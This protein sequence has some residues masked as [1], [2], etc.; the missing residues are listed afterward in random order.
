MNADGVRYRSGQG[1]GVVLAAVLGSGMAM[2]DGTV[3]NVALRS[4]GEDLHASLAQLQWI[5]NGY[6]LSLASLI[7]IGGSLGDRYGRRKIFLI[8]VVAFAVAS[9]ACGLAQGPT[10][11]ITARIIQGVGAALLTPGSLSMIQS[12]F[13][14][15]DRGPAIGAW[16]G[17][18][19]IA[20]AIGPFIGGGLLAVADW[21][22]LFWLNLPIA[23][24]TVLCTLRFVPESRSTRARQRFDLPGAVLGTL[25]LA[26]ITYALIEFEPHRTAALV[27]AAA[28]VVLA[29]AFIVTE[30]VR[31][32]AAMVPTSLFG[33]RNFSAANLMTLVTYAALGGVIFFLVLQLQTV[34]GYTPLAAGVATLPLTIMM[35][36]LA[37]TGGKVGARIGPRLPMS[38]GPLLCAIGTA[39]VAFIGPHVSYWSQVLPGMIIFGL[40][41]ST[42]VAPL[43]ATVLSSA[44]DDRVGIASGI[45]NAVARAGSLLAVAALPVAVG[46]SGHDYADPAVFG[47]GYRRAMLA[48][49]ALLVIGGAVSA[50]AIRNPGRQGSRTGQ[51][52]VR[53]DRISP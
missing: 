9:G 25:A 52:T 27:S 5:S 19:S 50:V 40:G 14:P 3:V 29:V 28:G 46:L 26:G 37:S 2:L 31:P 1:R 4:I 51:P 7:L 33:D 15:E 30:R 12:A 21:R 16:S 22:W 45:N 18:G 47:V 24:V 43:T 49:S 10:Q 6:L 35:L 44:P 11:L 39:W 41:L 34:S 38:I 20:V 53:R 42:L 36:L 23:V 48:C 13:V 17:L 32:N 8:G